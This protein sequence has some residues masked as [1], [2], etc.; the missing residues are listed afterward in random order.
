L[1]DRGGSRR[2]GRWELQR[3]HGARGSIGRRSPSGVLSIALIVGG[4]FCKVVGPLHDLQGGHHPRR[5][6]RNV[7]YT[8]IELPT[9]SQRTATP[10]PG[11]EE[12][13]TRPVS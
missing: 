1:R 12:T 9:R 3:P 8:L 4:T 6:E 2:G 10:A 13:H 5:L 7:G 11:P